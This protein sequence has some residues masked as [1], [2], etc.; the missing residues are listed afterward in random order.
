VKALGSRTSTCA[1]VIARAL[2]SAT[3]ALVMAC[4]PLLPALGQLP[5]QR[6]PPGTRTSVVRPPDPDSIRRNLPVPPRRPVGFGVIDGLV[7]DTMLAPL[8]DASIAVLS[9]S[10]RVATGPNGRFRLLRVPAGQYLLIVRKI[11][12]HP[13]SVVVD[14]PPNDTLRLAYALEPVIQTLGTVVVTEERRSFRLMQFEDRRNAGFGEFMTGE[15]IEKHN[16]NYATELIRQFMS[17][18]VLPSPGGGGSYQQ[19]AVST[20]GG[21]SGGARNCP[22]AIVVDDV[23]MPTP[24]DL[25]WLPSPRDLAGVEVYAGA[26]TIPL[27]FKSLDRG[28]GLIMIWTKVGG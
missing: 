16:S 3:C 25:D 6:P 20:R 28:C 18:R 26:A 11:G 13:T 27:Q 7:T 14:V 17:I 21:G 19:I 12:F 2:R 8:T 10:V 23:P 24:F 15:Q 9:S 5:P 22:M 4:A 1:P